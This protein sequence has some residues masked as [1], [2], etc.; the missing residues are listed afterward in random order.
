MYSMTIS[1]L[2]PTNTN[3]C[4]P[5]RQ[6]LVMSVVLGEAHPLQAGLFRSNSIGRLVSIVTGVLPE[7]LFFTEG[8]AI[9]LV[10]PITT[11]I[12]S[13]ASQLNHLSSWMG[14]T[15][16][17]QC[18]KS[19]GTELQSF[20]VKGIV[21]P[22]PPEDRQIESLYGN[23]DQTL[24]IPYFSASSTP[25]EDEVDLTQ[26]VYH[27]KQAQQHCSSEVVRA[28]IYRSLRGAALQTV[29]NL[30]EGI[31]TAQIFLDCV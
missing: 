5:L 19:S 12:L 6:S 25:A 13:V 8:S 14:R 26:W 9:L 28:W 7:K 22:L 31:Y 3:M 15:V 1:A 18:Y 27:V 23:A 16:K 17:V 2:S 11:D 21:G 10:F 24:H 30:G 20:G 29:I 4:M